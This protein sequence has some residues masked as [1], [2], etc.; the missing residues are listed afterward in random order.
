MTNINQMEIV[1]V[2]SLVP[3]EHPYRKLKEV[4]DFDRLSSGLNVELSETGAIGYTLPRLIMCLILQ[5]IEDI[6]DRAFERFL[7]ENNAAKL[8]CGFGLS[9]KT[10]DYTTV[11]KF[12]NKLGT[13][14]L[15]E[16]F[17]AARK[18]IEEKGHM[19]EIFTFVDSTALISKLQ[20]WEERDKAISEGYEKFTN[21][22]IE[23]YAKDKE[24]RIG[25]KGNKKFWF[26]FKKHVSVD[27]QS[28]MI[29]KVKV[30]KAN[31]ND[32]DEE[33]VKT[34]LPSQGAVTGDKG[35]VGAIPAIKESGLHPMIILKNNMANKN[36]D[37]DRFI[38]KL[39]SPFEGVFSKQQKRTRY[40][41][42]AKNQSA[43]FLYAIAH[44]LKRLLVLEKAALNF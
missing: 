39:R 10:P 16:L 30:T 27:M 14:Q 33:T 4:M 18:Q 26:G 36:K 40:K 37:L 19:Q 32:D 20:M 21:E 31:I 17:L 11:C 44:N 24:V 35:F 6:S 25:C 34:I 5:F 41:G 13:G 29:N 28:G 3:A 9:E 8:F 12:R 38:T 23:K 42:V 15:E 2:D 22:V 7:Q 1:S 43:E